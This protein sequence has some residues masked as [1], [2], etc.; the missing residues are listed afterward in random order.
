[1][2]AVNTNKLLLLGLAVVGYMI[3]S[4]RASANLKANQNVRATAPAKVASPQRNINGDMW[5]ALLGQGW[6]VLKN[7]GDDKGEK[8]FDT[9]EY[10]QQ[11]SDTGVPVDSGEA[12]DWL[13]PD[14]GAYGDDTGGAS[15]AWA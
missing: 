9:N 5:G 7:I 14:F 8:V 12:G 13:M 10:G 3:V 11:V 2:S 4:K 15:W 1:M 6:E